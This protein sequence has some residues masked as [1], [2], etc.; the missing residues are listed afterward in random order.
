VGKD[1]S[2]RDVEHKKRGRPKLVDKAVAIDGAW[3]ASSKD[4]AAF[5]AK[6]AATAAALAKTRVK[7][8]YTKSA[9]YKMPKKITNGAK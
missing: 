4:G 6:S 5:A 2:C 1:D 9:N 3:A 7:G 8:K